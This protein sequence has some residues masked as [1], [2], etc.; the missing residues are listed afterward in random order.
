MAVHKYIKHIKLGDLYTTIYADSNGF[1][2]IKAWR[3]K[4]NRGDLPLVTYFNEVKIKSISFED[5][6]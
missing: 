5:A 1:A 4:T 3:E 2:N 6:V